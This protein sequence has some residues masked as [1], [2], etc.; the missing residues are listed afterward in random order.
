V[1]GICAACNE[2]GSEKNGIFWWFVPFDGH[3]ARRE[4]DIGA[5]LQRKERY[6]SFEGGGDDGTDFEESSRARHEHGQ[7]LQGRGERG[8]VVDLH[9]LFGL[10][11]CEESPQLEVN[12]KLRRQR[13][14]RIRAHPPTELGSFGLT[15][16]R[17]STDDS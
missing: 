10:G 16:L 13:G 11:P 12:I 6:F 1:G 9:Q 5:S 15:T 8:K 3:L 2:D 14:V 4:E 7:E 17:R